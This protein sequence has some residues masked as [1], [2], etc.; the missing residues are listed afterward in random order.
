MWIECVIVVLCISAEELQGEPG[1][2]GLREYGCGLSVS[3]LCYVFRQ[4]NYKENQVLG[5]HACVHQRWVWVE[6]GACV[7]VGVG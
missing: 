1:S 6:C 2:W 4:K 5:L 7:S 3:L